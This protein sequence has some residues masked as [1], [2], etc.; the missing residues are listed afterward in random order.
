MKVEIV[1]IGDDLLVSDVLDTN[2]AHL[3]RSLREIHVPITCKVTVG[4]DVEMIADVLQIALKRANVVLTINSL[5]EVEKRIIPAAMSRLFGDMAGFTGDLTY[6]VMV[7]SR[8][9]QLPGVYIEEHDGLIVCLP[10]DRQEMSYVLETAVLPYLRAKAQQE[11]TK[12][13]GWNLLRAV[14]VVESSVRLQLGDMPR[15]PGTRITYDS[16]AGQTSIRLWAEG[17]TEELVAQKLALLKQGVM[18]RLGDHVFGEE[19]ARLEQVV[20][21][22]L[23]QSQTKLVVAEC[24]TNHIISQTLDNQPDSATQVLLLPIEN[25]VALAEYLRI[26]LESDDLTRWCREAAT[27][28]L[29]QSDADLSLMVYKNVTQGGI[30]V[31]VTLASESG[32]SV[33]QR[34]FGGHPDNIDRWAFSLGMTHLRR[35]LR[36]HA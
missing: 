3:S 25:C 10:R 33:T 11:A 23:V 34:S 9:V 14:G 5:Q 29:Y 16:F 17:E 22:L 26:P 1:S 31:L 12:K 8:L 18:E 32:V 7:D 20:L 30:Q 13:S 24:H 15:I 2:I 19:D 28:L 21:Q 36:A 6:S 35:W 27:Q 4:D